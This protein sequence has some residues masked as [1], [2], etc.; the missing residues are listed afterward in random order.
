MKK[1]IFY[2]ALLM[3]AFS[4]SLTYDLLA[5][6]DTIW[7]K[8]MNSVVTAV[9]FSPDGRYIY[10]AV[11]AYGPLKLD[12]NTGEILNEYQ[13]FKFGDNTF[14]RALSVSNDGRFTVGGYS[15]TLFLYDNN[16]GKIV[17]TYKY[18][19]E[20]VFFNIFSQVIISNDNKYVIATVG[21][22]LSANDK[23]KYKLCVWDMET[24][25]LLKSDEIT[26]GINIEQMR[27]KKYI[28]SKWL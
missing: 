12:A 25:K 21:Y 28:C 5:E 20:G 2:F 9:K 22:N 19:I 23:T 27:D 18:S 7:T 11:H 3:V 16:D 1:S 15:D 13:G 26:K 17:K 8:Y 14:F 10:A 6:S 4:N 24:T